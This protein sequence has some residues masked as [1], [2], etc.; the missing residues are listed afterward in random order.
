[1]FGELPLRV[2]FRWVA[3]SNHSASEKERN[4]CQ[5]LQGIVNGHV[6]IGVGVVVRAEDDDVGVAVVR[7]VAGG[8]VDVERL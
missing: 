7:E 2:D 4:F 3:Y 5:S 1:M 6:G 8:E